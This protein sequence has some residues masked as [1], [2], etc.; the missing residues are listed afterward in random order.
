MRHDRRV[1]PRRVLASV[2]AFAVAAAGIASARSAVA[3]P[4]APSSAAPT[5]PSTLTVGHALHALAPDSTLTSPSGAFTLTVMPLMAEVDQSI[6]VGDVPTVVEAP[7]W[8]T[9]VRGDGSDKSSLVLQTDGNL[10]L[11]SAAHRALWASGTKG[12]GAT[13]LVMQDDGNLVLYPASGPAVWATHTGRALL[14]PGSRLTAGQALLNR[15]SNVHG[16]PYTRLAMQTDGNLVVY[17]GRKAVWSTHTSVRGSVLTMQTD[18][19]LVLYSPAHR[20]LWSSRTSHAG[21]RSWAYVEQCGRIT[22][23]Q[24]ERNVVW[25]SSAAPTSGC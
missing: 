21:P 22:V 19:N 8:S 9:P 17:Y 1:H 24:L 13:R 12:S 10:V 18:G 7:T 6:K 25:A 23:N 20:A 3:V 16:G 14:P 2:L 11:Y 4:A 5:S 15:V